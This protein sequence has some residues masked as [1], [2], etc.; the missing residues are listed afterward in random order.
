MCV[1]ISPGTRKAPSA[2]STRVCAPRVWEASPNMAIRP[3]LTATSTPSSTSRVWTLTRRPPVM[4][5]SAGSR[6]MQTSDSVRV[7]LESEGRPWIM[8]GSFAPSV[9]S[10]AQPM[11]AAADTLD[12]GRESY[13]RHAWADAVR[14]RCP[15]RTRRR[16]LDARRPGA[17]RHRA[18]LIGHDDESIALFERA[19][20]AYLDRGDVEAAARCAF[21]LAFFL[22]G[23][24]QLERGG[25]WVARGRACSTP[26]ARLR[27]AG[28]PALRGRMM[29]IFA[30]RPRHGARH[31][32]A[33]ATRSATASPTPTS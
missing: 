20:H 21:W 33:G 13:G 23:G 11:P 30:R 19:H 16:A 31:V 4:T 5:R 26:T 29:A 25:G 28:L 6:P 18:Y 12:R 32:P 22:F 9:R 1:S 14:R 15:P 8:R 3:A 2:S 24:G 7:R 27:R 10:G 17:P